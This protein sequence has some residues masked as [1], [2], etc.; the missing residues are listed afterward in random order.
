MKL[1]A[2]LEHLFIFEFILMGILNLVK[3][4]GLQMLQFS[5]YED[6]IVIQ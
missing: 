3:A 1:S 5:I 4:L 6:E 2:F